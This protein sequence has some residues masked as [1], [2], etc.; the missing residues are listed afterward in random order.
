[1]EDF[2]GTLPGIEVKGALLRELKI[3]GTLERVEVKGQSH[4]IFEL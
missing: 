3:N 4:K 2:W 1:M